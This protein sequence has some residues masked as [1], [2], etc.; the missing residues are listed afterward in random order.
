MSL[1]QKAAPT[2]L[3]PVKRS[4]GSGFFLGLV[5]VGVIFWFLYYQYYNIILYRSQVAKI[6][7]NNIQT[8]NIENLK[9]SQN[10]YQAPADGDICSLPTP[11][12]GE[13]FFIGPPGS[14]SIPPSKLQRTAYLA[15]ANFL[16]LVMSK[17]VDLKGQ[18]FLSSG[19]GFFVNRDTILTNRR[20]VDGLGPKGAILVSGGPLTREVQARV[21]ALSRPESLRDYALL[22]IEKVD[23]PEPP[24]KGLPLFGEANVYDR[25]MA[26]GYP[27]LRFPKGA[28]PEPVS[29]QGRIGS[30]SYNLTPAIIGHNAETQRRYRGGPLV[31]RQGRVI[32]LSAIISMER[33]GSREIRVALMASD[34]LTFLNENFVRLD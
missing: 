24:I 5:L 11:K 8:T 23:L 33:Y 31:D 9:N 34:V 2:S 1:A 19:A 4:Y 15:I 13:P 16:V 30:I 3:L 14:A 7:S 18:S 27:D 6:D 22:K 12:D 21:L 28:R 10:Q 29:S 20:I 32:G 25:V 26:L 17:G